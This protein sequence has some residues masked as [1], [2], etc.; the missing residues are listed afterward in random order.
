MKRF[1]EYLCVFAAV[2]T[3][4]IQCSRTSS[5]AGN[6]SSE[7]TNGIT[8][9]VYESNGDPTQGAVVRLRKIDYVTQP[10]LSLAK[11][12]IYEADALTDELA[13]LN[14]KALTRVHTVSRSMDSSTGSGHGNNVLFTCSIAANDTL[15][16]APDTVRPF[17][18]VT[19]SIDMSTISGALYVQIVRSRAS[20]PGR[21][22]RRFLHQ[23]SSGRS[24]R[25]A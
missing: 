19:G 5:I 25:P 8:A 23:G 4:G 20:C 13:G 15:V 11:P 18:V 3:I 6:T 10:P 2:M 22:H 17:A 9:S 24:F 16:L 1:Y 7:T 12:T 14:S 21:F